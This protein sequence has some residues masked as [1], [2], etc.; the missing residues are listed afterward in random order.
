[1]GLEEIWE[2]ID[3]NDDE[4]KE[5]KKAGAMNPDM[6]K[7]LNKNVSDKKLN[8]KERGSDEFRHWSRLK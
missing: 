1:M 2:E 8:E 6:M 5:P 4:K 3:E 7:F